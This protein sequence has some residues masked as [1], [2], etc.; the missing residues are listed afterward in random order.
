MARQLDG[1]AFE[2]A[3]DGPLR[4][5]ILGAEGAMR[6]VAGLWSAMTPEEQ[7][8]WIEEASP[9]LPAAHVMLQTI[10]PAT[11]KMVREAGH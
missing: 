6:A 2:G 7:E 9:F 4:Q 8:Q 5:A 1:N 11:E 3:V 10:L